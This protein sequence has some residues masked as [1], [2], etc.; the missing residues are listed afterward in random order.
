MSGKAPIDLRIRLAT[1]SDNVLLSCLGA[2]TFSDTFAADNSPEDMAAYLSGAFNPGRQ[3]LELAEPASTFLVAEVEGLPVGYTRLRTGAAPEAV[4]GRRPIEI[5]RFY[6][7]KEWIGHGVGARLMEACLLQAQRAE[8]DVVWLDVWERNYRAIGFYTGWG[9]VE[10]GSQAF[11]LG[12]DR[13]R[14]LLMARASGSR[15][16]EEGR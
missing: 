9:F 13:Q 14:D 3:A 8:C 12:E 5:A 11:Q 2:E 16:K 6:A 4:R 7:Q 1:A 10:V 15:Q